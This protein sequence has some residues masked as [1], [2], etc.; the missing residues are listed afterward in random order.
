MH[1][2]YREGGESGSN[3]NQKIRETPTIEIEEIDESEEEE[4]EEEETSKEGCED[5]KELSRKELLE[6]IAN[7]GVCPESY[8]WL[9]GKKGT[10]MNPTCGID[11]LNGFQCAGGSH[12]ICQGCV[13]RA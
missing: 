7:I 13:N 6:K 4:E 12:F 1:G 9:S 2:C 8:E 10:C 11:F 5:K 3:D